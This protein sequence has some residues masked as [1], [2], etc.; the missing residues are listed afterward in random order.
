MSDN[1][2]AEQAHLLSL[3]AAR[4]SRQPFFMASALEA[5]R[6][7]TDTDEAGLATRLEIET[8]KLSRL[9]LCR[10]PTP[11]ESQ[12]FG[13]EV[14]AIAEKFGI[15]PAKLANLLRQ[16]ASYE[17][18]KTARPIGLMAARDYSEDE[19]ESETTESSNET[20]EP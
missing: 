20:Q 15:A 3:A 12:S 4:A 10:R 18:D 16:V 1:D 17:A 2:P 8:S 11:A 14:Q 5:F 19:A 9:A 13:R 7:A 6:Q